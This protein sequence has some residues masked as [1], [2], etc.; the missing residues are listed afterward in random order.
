MGAAS[1]RSPGPTRLRLSA[2]PPSTTT[3]WR[4]RGWAPNSRAKSR[5]QNDASSRSSDHVSKS[6]NAGLARASQSN[7]AVRVGVADTPDHDPS[8][9]AASSAGRNQ[10][11]LLVPIRVQLHT[12]VLQPH[13]A[14]CHEPQGEGIE[15]VLLAQHARGQCV[16]R[17]ARQHRHRGL[18]DDRT[19]VELGHDV[20]HAAAVDAHA[21]FE[22]ATVGVQALE[23]RQKRRVDVDHPSLPTLDQPRSQHAHETRKTQD[24][25]LMS[26]ERRVEVALEGFAVRVGL[27]VDAMDGD[28]GVAGPR[29]ACRFRPVGQ[30]AD[31]LGWVVRIASGLDQREHVRAAP[32]DQDRDPALPWHQSLRA[33]LERTRSPSGA[34][35]TSPRAKGHSPAWRRTSA[36]LSAMS[37]PAMTIMPTPQLNVRSSSLST[38]P[39]AV[40][41]QP[42]TGGTSIAGSSSCTPIPAGS[43]RGMLSGNPPPVM[44]TRPLMPLLAFSAESSG[45]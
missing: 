43:T 7:R 19:G 23:K 14:A 20:V 38:T 44:W 16:F 15:H 39:P 45:F 37:A 40:A 42:K 4:W 17:V 41:S 13:A 2:A 24:V 21:G 8:A 30:H 26:R 35:I 25:G 32:G 5:P 28:A 10:R 1:T 27:V 3:G 18:R 36:T 29:K 33:P 12:T 11:R 34:A 31:D 9:F 6:W 22:R